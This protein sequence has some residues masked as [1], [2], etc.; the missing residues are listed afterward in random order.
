MNGARW[1]TVQDLFWAARELPPNERDAVLRAACGGDAGLLEEVRRMLA[2]D[3][4][5][6]IL[7]HTSPITPLVVVSRIQMRT[8]PS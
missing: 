2:G 6:G 4:H 8:A 7:D 1:Q 3:A 5:D